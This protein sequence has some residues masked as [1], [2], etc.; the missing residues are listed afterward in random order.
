M[1]PGP[2]NSDENP[3]S[4]NNDNSVNKSGIYSY[5]EELLKQ[6]QL[7]LKEQLA[8]LQEQ[9]GNIRGNSENSIN[10]R[11]RESTL[12]W[13]ISKIDELIEHKKS[14][15]SSDGTSSSIT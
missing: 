10:N 6:K 5:V 9:V 11:L 8:K 7:E 12:E 1:S 13:K 4:F 15:G 3:V 14:T 2:I